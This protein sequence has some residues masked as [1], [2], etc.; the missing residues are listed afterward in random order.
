ML[1]TL[2]FIKETTHM[3]HNDMLQCFKNMFQA[4]QAYEWMN[5]AHVHE[6][7]VQKRKPNTWGVTPYR[8]SSATPC[9]SGGMPPC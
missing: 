3:K 2:H 7:Q 6:M 4:T 8:R 9:S 5:D 1:H